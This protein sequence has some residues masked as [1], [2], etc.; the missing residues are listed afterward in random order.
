M[1][2]DQYLNEL[3]AVEREGTSA[4][5]AAGD[6]DALESVRVAFLGDRQGRVKALQ[7]ALKSIGKN[8]K[9]AAGKRFNEVRTRL[10]S[11]H[12]DRKTALGRTGH[13]GAKE[14]LSL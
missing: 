13:T 8:D 12:D 11:L 5:G 6:L 1:N 14:D 7:E 4:L 9:P 2:L 10:Q 3:D